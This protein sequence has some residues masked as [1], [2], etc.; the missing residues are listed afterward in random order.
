MMPQPKL[1]LPRST[2]KLHLSLVVILLSILSSWAASARACLPNNFSLLMMPLTVVANEPVEFSVSPI[3]SITTYTWD[4]DGAVQ[5]VNPSF[6]HSFTPGSY[7]VRV[8][9]WKTGCENPRVKAVTF[10]VPKLVGN[11]DFD[12]LNFIY[13]GSTRAIAAHIAEEPATS[14]IISESPVGPNAGS[15]PVT[16][17]C[18][19]IQYTASANATV[20][21][22]KATGTVAFDITNFTYDGNGKAVLAHI[23]EESTSSCTV[24]QSPI[25]PNAG[26]YFVTA[27][28]DGANYVATGNV[29]ASIGMAT[30]SVLSVFA[31]PSDIPFGESSAL[32][33]Q[34]GSG[35]GAVSYLVSKGTENCGI[36]GP[37]LTGIGL[38][39]CNVIAIKAADQNHLAT[40]AEAV[41][42]VLPKADLQLAKDVGQ[43]GALIGDTVIF[44]LVAANAGP[45]DVVGARLV[46]IPPATLTNVEWACHPAGSSIPC[47]SSPNQT[48]DGA[49]DVRIDLPAGQHLRYDLTGTVTGA[50]GAYIQNQASLIVP[51]GVTDPAT[52]NGGIASVLI[53]P[54]GVFIDGFEDEEEEISLTDAEASRTL[55]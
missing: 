27:N 17:T 54:E 48:G 19:G 33:T 51:D 22:E 10:T 31:D 9:A 20:N 4:I 11:V 35:T 13:D 8:T 38:G 44:T 28:C 32:S 29:V 7:V 25:G 49:M 34:G 43:A 47:P 50:V 36:D 52:P 3:A 37:T 15:Y 24:P 23:A 2:R 6:T 53:V 30:Q 55:Q 26:N 21:I 5:S 40:S 18:D 42:N 41:V 46:D 45:N 39:S 16:A 14:C 12:T 1:S